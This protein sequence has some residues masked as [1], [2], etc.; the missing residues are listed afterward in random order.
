M[1]RTTETGTI[2][3][4]NLCWIDMEM[5]GLN[6]ATDAVLEIASLVT[7]KDLNVIGEGPEIVI[8]QPESVIAGM[9]EWAAKH[10][11]ESGLTQRVRES[12]ISLEEAERLTIE[13][14]AQFAPPKT[15]PLCGNSVHQDRRFVVRYMPELD[16]FLHYRIVDVSTIKELVRRWYPELR[17]PRK[18]GAHRALDDIKESIEELRF[19]RAQVFK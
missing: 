3:A 13:F 19:Y 15:S 1:Q 14:F 6:P 10:H 17:V 16:E 4:G 12:T 11:G 8:H 18:Q 9:D 2:D 7:D 5:T